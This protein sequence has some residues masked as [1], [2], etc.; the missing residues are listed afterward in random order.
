[1]SGLVCFMDA[2]NAA[3]LIA[4]KCKFQACNV[5]CKITRTG[6]E[7]RAVCTPYQINLIPLAVLKED[8]EIYIFIFIE[9]QDCLFQDLKVYSFSIN[10]VKTG[11]E[12]LKDIPM[13]NGIFN[14]LSFECNTK[15][16][17]QTFPRHKLNI[18]ISV[19]LPN[20]FSAWRI[21][22]DN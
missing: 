5:N 18:S 8:W 12:C 4:C 15:Y 2:P 16:F 20:K 9:F 11:T 10:N 19:C 1:M 13:H 22:I 14:R 17:S 6:T 7:Q 21:F 3:L